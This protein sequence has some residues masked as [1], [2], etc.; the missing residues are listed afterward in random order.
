M[1][2]LH[3][4]ITQLTKIR[5]NPVSQNFV[6]ETSMGNARSPKIKSVLEGEMGMFV[7]QAVAGMQITKDILGSGGQAW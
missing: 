6:H 5:Y 7:F 2:I 4:S 3:C 1:G